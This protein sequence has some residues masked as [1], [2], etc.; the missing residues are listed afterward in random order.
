ML[1]SIS[2]IIA[3]KA[4]KTFKAAII[5]VKKKS[6]KALE[7]LECFTFV[8]SKLVFCLINGSLACKWILSVYYLWFIRLRSSFVFVNPDPLIINILYGWPEIK[9]IY[10]FFCN[11]I[12]V[13]HFG[14]VLFH[15]YINFFSF[16]HTRS[17]LVPYSFI[18]IEFIHYFLLSSLAVYT[19]FLTYSVN[20]L[21]F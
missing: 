10:V 8:N 9:L 12:K 5:W 13:S 4:F 17:F 11:T 14:I 21:C 18:S 7:S 2:A 3:I 1:L 19:V 6:I 20:I 16:L 15:C